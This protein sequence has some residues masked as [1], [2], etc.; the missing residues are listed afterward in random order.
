MEI[1]KDIEGSVKR[2]YSE[3]NEVYP[4]TLPQDVFVTVQDDNID[5]SIFSFVIY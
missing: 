5:I 3:E 4:L 1:L 2:I